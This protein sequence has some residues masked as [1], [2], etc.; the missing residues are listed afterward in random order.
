[1]ATD[2]ATIT[3]HRYL[4]KERPFPVLLYIFKQYAVSKETCCK[5]SY[6]VL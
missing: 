6:N 3:N 1:M 4:D 2:A 5:S